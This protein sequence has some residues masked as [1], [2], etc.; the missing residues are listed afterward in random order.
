LLNARRGV[1]L[2]ELLVAM[3]LLG[4]ITAAF[5]L[6]GLRQEENHR[7]LAMRSRARVQLREAVAA[8]PIELRG[9][10]PAD[11]DIPPGGARD[12]TLEFRSTVAV[13]VACAVENERI[14]LPRHSSGWT[15]SSMLSRPETGDSAWF[16]LAGEGTPATWVGRGIASVG[17]SSGTCGA[18]EPEDAAGTR[19]ILHLVTDPSAP[20]V[21]PGAPVRV[22]RRL[23][24]SIYRSSTDGEW[25]LGAREWNASMERFD[26]VQPIAGPFTSPRATRGL[27]SR[28]RYFDRDDVEL[29]SGSQATTSIGRLLVTLCAEERLMRDRG[30]A[31]PG[32]C[33]GDD[34]VVAVSFRDRR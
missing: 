33:A 6:T 28:F 20:R 26:V 4:I 8:L 23:R 21:V 24:Y 29:A 3:T 1:T 19:A 22:T 16:L 25:Y 30:S 2:V 5:M 15:H 9:V 17:A 10:S 18:Y 32:P 34:A 27:P 12:S 13:G 7:S 14:E 11:G 31:A